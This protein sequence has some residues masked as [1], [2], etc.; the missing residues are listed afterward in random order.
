MNATDRKALAQYLDALAAVPISRYE[1]D[2]QLAYWINLYNALTVKVILD[3][4]PVDSIRDINISPGWFSVG[5][6][7]RS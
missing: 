3:H 2:E 5:P 6:W 4:Y 7:T 1:R